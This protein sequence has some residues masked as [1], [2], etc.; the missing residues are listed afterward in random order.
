MSKKDVNLNVRMDD[1]TMVDL[2]KI[3]DKSHKNQSEI[4]RE[5]IR[6]GKVEYVENGKE[7]VQKI[8]KIHADINA[9]THKTERRFLELEKLIQENKKSIELLKENRTGEN[10]DEVFD[11]LRL[12]TKR[13]M[14]VLNGIMDSYNL[15]KNAMERGLDACVDF[16]S[17]KKRV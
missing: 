3:Q 8:G 13:E 12:G 10:K 15:K 16:S 4:V 1:Q 9:Y 6:K 14:I 5:L 7:M 11:L 17:D 2:K